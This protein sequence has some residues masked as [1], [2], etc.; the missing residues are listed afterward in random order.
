MV[1]YK[2]REKSNLSQY[3]FRAVSTKRGKSGDTQTGFPRYSLR[4]AR[5]LCG[6]FHSHCA[7]WFFYRDLGRCH[8]HSLKFWRFHGYVTRLIYLTKKCSHAVVFFGCKKGAVFSIPKESCF[9]RDW[10]YNWLNKHS[11]KDSSLNWTSVDRIEP[12]QKILDG[13]S[14]RNPLRILFRRAPFVTTDS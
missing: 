1:I 2:H 10:V 5:L 7:D 11:T 8:G 6:K 4:A 14:S 3:I 13:L 12:I 9:H